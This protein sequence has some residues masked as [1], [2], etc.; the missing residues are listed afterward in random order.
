MRM[1]NILS[2]DSMKYMRLN[3]ADTQFLD[4]FKTI[5]KT[6]KTEKSET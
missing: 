5:M 2:A 4:T 3:D 6:V 1:R